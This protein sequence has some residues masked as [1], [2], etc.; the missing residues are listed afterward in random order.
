PSSD[1][2]GVM[3]EPCA[4]GFGAGAVAPVG[5]ENLAES[6]AQR[7]ARLAAEREQGIER[8]AGG[9]LRGLRGEAVEQLKLERGCKIE[10]VVADRDAAACGAAGWGE[11]AERQVLDREVGVPVRRGDPGAPL[12]SVSLVDHGQT[13]RFGGPRA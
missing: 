7:A 5:V 12:R 3:D 2:L 1:L 11:H 9:G 8:G 4:Q 6:A 10:N 13:I